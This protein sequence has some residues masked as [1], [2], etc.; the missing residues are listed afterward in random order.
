M[1]A[2]EQQLM[3]DKF[4]QPSIIL[5]GDEKREDI[6]KFADLIDENP[7]FFFGLASQLRFLNT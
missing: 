5:V 4:E 1:K 2:F 7:C 3:M 6:C